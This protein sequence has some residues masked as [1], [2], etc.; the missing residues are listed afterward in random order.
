MSNIFDPRPNR[1]KLSSI[2]DEEFARRYQTEGPA[3]MAKAIGVSAQSVHARRAKVEAKLG[4]ILTQPEVSLPLDAPGPDAP[5][6]ELNV[7]DGIVFVGGDGHYWPGYTP[8]AHLAFCELAR[9]MAPKVVVFNGDALDGSTISRHPPIGW[10]D[11]PSLEQELAV[12]Q[13]RLGEIEAATPTARHLWPLG[14]HDARFN[15]RL[16]SMAPEFRNVEG[17]RLL[18]HFPAWEPCWAAFIN[19]RD[20]VVVKHRFKGG[21]HAPHN[22]TLWAGRSIVTGHLHSLKVIPITD[23]NGTRYGVDCGCLAAPRGPQF[24]Y[25][26]QNPNNWRSGF[27]VLTFRN[28]HLLPPEL[29]T[30]LNEA[31]RTFHW[32][33][34]VMAL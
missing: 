2:P 8:T 27:A 16:A 22:N 32:R 13:E 1:G 19:G 20:G 5:R 7:H 3:E 6:L 15:T 25:T 24:N 21:V 10:E 14:N 4:I 30:V 26:E 12:V 33:G 18:H 17:T 29:C 11:L 34:E 28:G 23:Y 9:V 31:E